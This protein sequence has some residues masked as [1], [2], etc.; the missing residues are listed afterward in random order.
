MGTWP[1]GLLHLVLNI[2]AGVMQG[3][4]LLQGR[5]HAGKAVEICKV[6]AADMRRYFIESTWFRREYAQS[7]SMQDR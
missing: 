3:P 1:N 4:W 2:E 6:S 5:R 7:K